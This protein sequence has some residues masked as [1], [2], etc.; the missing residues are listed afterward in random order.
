[1]V[2]NSATPL[3][4]CGVQVICVK[5]LALCQDTE[6]TLVTGNIIIC[7][8]ISDICDNKK[9]TRS[10]LFTRTDDQLI[11]QQNKI[12]NSNNKR[13]TGLEKLRGQ[14]ES[15]SS[16][17]PGIDKASHIIVGEVWELALMMIPFKT[18]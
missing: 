4:C 7:D 6:Y 18:Q 9:E 3:Y 13:N 16:S 5:Y 8:N 14:T 15:A 12:H 17:D 1:M 11:S 10:S 2:N